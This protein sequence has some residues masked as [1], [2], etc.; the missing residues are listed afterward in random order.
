[1]STGHSKNLAGIAAT[2]IIALSLLAGCGSQAPSSASQKNAPIQIGYIG[3][4]SGPGA[5]Y[6]PQEEEQA[7]LAVSQINASGGVMG[8]KLQLVIKDSATDPNTASIAAKQLIEQVNVPALFM[9]DTSAVRN[10][11]E[12]VVKNQKVLFFYDTLYEGGAYLPNMYIDGEVP[13]QQVIPVYPYI[14][15]KYHGKKWFIVGD[16]YVWP[17]KT[18]AVVKATVQK[19]GGS[20]VGTSYVPLGTSNFSSVLTQIQAAR[21]NFLSMELIGTD[22]IAFMKQF[23]ALGLEHHTKVVML[24]IDNGTL[25][26]MG[27]AG[28]GSLEPAGYFPAVQS[29][30]NTKYLKAY[31]K[32][33]PQ[34]PPPSFNIIP[35][36]D[37]IMLWAKAANAAKSLNFNK[38]QAMMT[39][40]SF[41]S[42]RGLLRYQSS[43]HGMPL[44]IY[45]A[46]FEPGGTEKIIHTFGDVQ[47]G[48]Q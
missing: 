8:R 39:K 12:S 1:M 43:T 4:F 14:M 7:K 18:S 24:A 2:G 27:Q 16:D 28:V 23:Y 17:T 41:D 13:Q 46:Q 36:Y 33:F 47:P 48:P 22:A 6:G 38:V 32:M 45:L 31:N 29:A 35:V 15:Q 40:V 20:V 21:P 5:P 34:A 44:T 3:A 25:Q 19:A 9:C 10:A 30:A 42:P 37:S 26:A 11:V